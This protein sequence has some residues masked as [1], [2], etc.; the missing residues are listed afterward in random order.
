M[1]SQAIILL[2]DIL[3]ELLL[4]DKDAHATAHAS[5]GFPN[6]SEPGGSG[7][8]N[9]VANLYARLMKLDPIRPNI[10]IIETLNMI[11]HDLL[12]DHADRLRHLVQQVQNA[13]ASPGHVDQARRLLARLDSM[14]AGASASGIGA[15]RRR[16]RS[17]PLPERGESARGRVRYM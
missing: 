14:D 6:V 4:W 16:S 1:T 9:P 7:R 8:N 15:G 2:C 17:P 12:L 13:G 3:T 10:G 5:W 11:G